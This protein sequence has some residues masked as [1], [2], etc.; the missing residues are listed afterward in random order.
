M[1]CIVTRALTALLDRET[2]MIRARWPR[3]G[4]WQWNLSVS[5]ILIGTCA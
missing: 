1:R 5:L 3:T 2:V 4:L